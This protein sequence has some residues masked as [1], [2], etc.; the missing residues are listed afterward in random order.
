MLYATDTET[1][2][3][4]RRLTP[5]LVCG[6]FFDGINPPTVLLAEDYLKWFEDALADGHTFV[7][8][9]FPY[10]LGVIMVAADHLVEPI[11]KALSEGRFF[12][13]MIRETLIQNALG[14]TGRVN[15]DAI[16][17]RRFGVAL[18][19]KDTTRLNFSTL[20][21]LPLD[22]WPKTAVKYAVDDAVWT[23][24]VYQSQAG[25]S[26]ITSAG[27]P[28]MPLEDEQ[29]QLEAA[30]ALHLCAV[31]GMKTDPT[32]V[33]A[34][35]DSVTKVAE[36]GKAMARDLGFMRD[37]GSR[38]M[39]ALK[40]LVKKAYDGKPPTTEKGAVSTSKEVL[41]ESKDPA[42][43]AYA[44]TL[45]AAK[46]VSTYAPILAAP[47]VHPR[48]NAIV[49]TGRTSCRKPNMQNPPREGGFRA[50]FVPRSREGFV[51]VS[52]DYSQI[53]LVALAQ[54]NLWWFGAS[55]MAKVLKR[56][57][58]IHCR[59]VADLKGW[60][61]EDTVKRHKAGDP[62]VKKARQMA[63][64]VL[65]GLPGGLGAESLV[66]FMKGS[67][68]AITVEQAERLKAQYLKSWPEMVLYFERASKLTRFGPATIVHPVSNRQRGGLTFCQCLNTPFQGLTADGAKAALVAVVRA[69]FVEPDSPL[70]G[71]H[72][73]LFLHDEIMIEA[74]VA[75]A[76]AA[77]TELSRLMVK[78]MGRYIPDIPVEAEPKIS[79]EWVK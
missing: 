9:N 70:A 57:D 72:P 38:N 28:V 13:T 54:L 53:E 17:N 67:G 76:E 69:C 65:Y 52:A 26:A 63:K 40:D 24:K 73:C 23:L 49:G 78:V 47:S 14:H 68:V 25:E 37:N 75:K 22:Q 18:A 62:E 34:F 10:D 4:G 44:K 31:W 50:C 27:R 33:K 45:S 19:G 51:Y 39:K 3:I 74:P 77:A 2:L 20:D 56:G 35:I 42:L 12:D 5:R 1:Y 66:A 32:R 48:Y 36:E 29:A 8:Q 41:E 11:F 6:Q 55:Q 71:C 60:S 58:D 46:M 61:Y 30:L 43:I 16:V 64:G 7:G 59:F 79:T 15:L 21:G